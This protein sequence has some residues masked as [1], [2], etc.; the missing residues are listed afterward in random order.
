MRTGEI[1]TAKATCNDCH[2]R[3]LKGAHTGVPIAKGST[4]GK[5]VGCGECHND[6]RA[7]GLAEVLSDWKKRA[8]EDCH[9]VNSSSPMHDPEVA[10]S[11]E[12]TGTLGCGETGSGCHAE[13]DLHA[14]HANAP[15]NCSGKAEKGEPGCHDFEIE[16][17][18][19]TARGCG[20]DSD[21]ACHPDYVNDD[22]SHENDRDV[23]SPKTRV[24]A[25]NTTYYGIALRRVPL[26]GARRRE[27]A[28]RARSSLLGP[29][30]Q[31]E[32][33]PELPRRPRLGD[34]HRRGLVD[35]R[36]RRELRRVPRHRRP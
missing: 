18:Q 13:N 28:D 22:Y 23:H 11:V 30:E 33:L 16:A 36:H 14:L 8:C 1:G 31:P 9:K 25:S 6:V 5:D 29:L 21:G 34:R 32:H 4:Y 35:A 3:D 27:P 12:A 7:F 24:P 19:P 15:E 2:S 26:H 17:H 10:Q 20:A